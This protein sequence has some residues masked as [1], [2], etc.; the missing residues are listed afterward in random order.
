MCVSLCVNLEGFSYGIES[1][2]HQ[3]DHFDRATHSTLGITA[4]NLCN[5][6]CLALVDSGREMVQKD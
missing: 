2:S 1:N 5:I 4:L 6:I 3:I